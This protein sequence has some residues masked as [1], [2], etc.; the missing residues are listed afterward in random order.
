MF[1]KCSKCQLDLSVDNFCKDK[2]KL[3]GLFIW[4]NSCRKEHYN[5]TKDKIKIYRGNNKDIISN[6]KKEYYKKRKDYFLKKSKDYYKNNSAI[7][8]EKSKIY[9][10]INKVLIKEKKKEW[11]VSESGKLSHAK[12][13]AKY[14]Q[15]NKDK[16]RKSQIKS[17]EKRLSTD[18]IFKFKEYF[19]NTFRSYLKKNSLKKNKT[20]SFVILGYSLLDL[21]KDIESKF[22]SWMTWNNQGKY[23]PNTWD[24]NNTNTWKWQLDHIIP[25]SNFSY[26]SFNDEEFK[27]CWALNNLRPYSAKQNWLDGINRTRHK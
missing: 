10:E 5:L 23:N 25:H 22:E 2:R 16:V 3:D 8:S 19:S 20:N 27:K 13:V 1:K 14:A 6:K 21:K 24:D 17:K 12:S 15:N 7:I 26:S 11:A 18:P 9:R 4:C